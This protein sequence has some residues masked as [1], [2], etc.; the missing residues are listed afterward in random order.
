MARPLRIEVP[1]ALYHVTARGNAQRDIF[2]DDE[3]RQQF[4]TVLAPGLPDKRLFNEILRQ[5]RFAARSTLGQMRRSTVSRII[6][7]LLD[8]HDKIV[9]RV[10]HE[11]FPLSPRPS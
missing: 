4:L 11:T 6:R 9:S 1:D 10:S 2:L 3:D 7:M 5:Q 8:G